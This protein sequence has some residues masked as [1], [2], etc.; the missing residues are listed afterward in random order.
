VRIYDRGPFAKGRIIDLSRA[1]ARE[2]ALV[3]PGTARVRVESIDGPEGPPGVVAYAVQAGAFQDGDKAN[4]LRLDLAS[5]FE[6]VYLTPLRT[7]DAL[8][9]RVRLGPFERR[10]DAAARARMLA[11]NGVPAII[12][13]EV[14]P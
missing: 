4:G 8:Y 11:R 10:D 7:S 9:Y 12:V 13:E 3:G 2:I 6:N 5:R 1:A 14:R